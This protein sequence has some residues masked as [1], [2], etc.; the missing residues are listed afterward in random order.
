MA[1]ANDCPVHADDADVTF[2]SC[3]QIIFKVHRKNLE[4]HSEGFAPPD[5]TS[6]PNEVVL[7]AERADVLELLFQYIYPLRQPN[8]KTI[9]FEVLSRLSEAAEK[10]QV[11]SAMEICSVRMEYVSLQNSNSQLRRSQ[12]VLKPDRHTHS[13]HSRF[14]FMQ[15]NT[16][17]LI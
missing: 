2:E 4:T 6:S 12:P 15:P 10:Y 9:E 13:I 7:L 3:D 16:G 14:C 11:Y 1:S 5:G 8:L 17:T